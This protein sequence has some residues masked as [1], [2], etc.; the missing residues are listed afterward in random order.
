MGRAKAATLPAEEHQVTIFERLDT[1]ARRAEEEDPTRPASA[2]FC[3]VLALMGIGLLMQISHA[4][5]TTTPA[6][7]V[8]AIREHALFRLGGVALMFL[9]YKIGPLRL[10]RHI[11]ALTV[12]AGLALIACFLPVIGSNLN[13]ASRWI[14]LPGFTIQPSELARIAVVLWVADRCMRLGHEVRDMRKGVLPILALGL[15]FFFLILIETDVG[16]AMLL[17]ICL[18]CTMWV[19]GARPVHVAGSLVGVGGGAL[20]FALSSLSYVR[21]RVEMWLGSV[22]NSQV[23]STLDAMSSGDLFG[24][25]LAGGVHRNAGVPYLESDYVFA[26]IGEELGLVGMLVV[27]GLWISFVWFALKLSLS[28]RDRFCALTAFGL[29]IAVGCQAML[30]VQVVTGLAPPKGMP[31]PFISD[32]GTSLLASALAVGLALGA[33]K[34]SKNLLSEEATR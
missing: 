22:Q 19:G 8:E 15:T 1:L 27:L 6:G 30:H 11:P 33:A 4:A 32:G 21:S 7:L 2:I 16:G 18:A 17:L 24:M 5:T 26:L 31:L 25:G 23:L 28:I 34:D 14:K 29:L 3:T 10:R 13:G 20:L 12:L 9:A